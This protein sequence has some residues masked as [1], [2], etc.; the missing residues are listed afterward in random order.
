[1]TAAVRCEGGNAASGGWFFHLQVDDVLPVR[2]GQRRPR[3]REM[4]A[5]LL[6]KG[7][8]LDATDVVLGD[9]PRHARNA[10]GDR[11]PPHQRLH[12]DILQPK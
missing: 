3:E 2:I 7:F 6:R 8:F 4:V 10:G 1:M 11:S 9:V 5:E 12:V